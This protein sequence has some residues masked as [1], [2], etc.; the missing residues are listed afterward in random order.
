MLRMEK[1]WGLAMTILGG[2]AADTAVAQD[3]APPLPTGAAVQTAIA[4]GQLPPDLDPPL[5]NPRDFEGV[6]LPAATGGGQGG[7]PPGGAGPAPSSASANGAPNGLPAGGGAPAGGNSPPGG[8]DGGPPA[9]AATASWCAPNQV[10]FAAGAGFAFGIVQSPDTMILMNEESQ[11]YRIIYFT[12]K[13]PPLSQIPATR[14]GHSIAHWEGNTLVVD[15]LGAVGRDGKQS[16]THTIEHVHKSDDG[17]QLIIESDTGN[18]PA[19]T[20]RLQWRPDNFISESVCEESYGEFV[21]RDGVTL[22]K[23]QVESGS[24]P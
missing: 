2:I 11:N 20:S 17:S 15:T 16:T 12:D 23:Q 9:G 19:R 18:G 22:L 3:I 6:W 24:K 4:H 7:P 8:G 21:Q 14:N 1:T 5:K 13:H 10:R